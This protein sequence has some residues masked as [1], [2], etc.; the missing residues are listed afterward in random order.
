MIRVH[1][2]YCTVEANDCQTLSIARPL[3]DSIVIYFIR[4]ATKRTSSLL[5]ESTHQ[6]M[7]ST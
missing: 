2:W 7:E 5:Y 3:C 4:S 1:S 6:N